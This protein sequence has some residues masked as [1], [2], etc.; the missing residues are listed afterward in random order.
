GLTRVAQRRMAPQAARAVVGAFTALVIAA[1][2][3]T[4]IAPV[5]ISGLAVARTLEVPYQHVHPDYREA[6]YYIRAHWQ[7]GDLMIAVAPDLMAQYYSG[8][9]PQYFIYQ[10]KALYLYNEDNHIVDTSLGSVA[11]L[12]R[13]DYGA[14]LAKYHRVWLFSSVTYQCCGKT[15][16]F[17]IAAN[18]NLVFQ[19]RDS[20]VYFRSG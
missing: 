4:M 8:I 16:D 14:V 13:S 17:A 10:S 9:F 2:L 11:L 7:P 5:S 18:F 15:D 12:N 19:G 20:L 6:A 3:I 1:S